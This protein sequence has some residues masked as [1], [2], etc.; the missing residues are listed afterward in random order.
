[1][2]DLMYWRIKKPFQYLFQWLDEIIY[3]LFFIH[4]SGKNYVFQP[5]KKK[6]WLRISFT[7]EKKIAKKCVAFG[8]YKCAF[9]K[10][11][12]VESDFRL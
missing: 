7:D 5:E 8:T 6:N 10:G 12:K 11:S 1:M 2:K 3:L 4:K 9:L